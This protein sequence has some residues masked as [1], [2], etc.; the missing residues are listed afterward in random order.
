MGNDYARID[1]LQKDINIDTKQLDK[2]KTVFNINRLSYSDNYSAKLFKGTSLDP[3][4]EIDAISK[5]EE[6]CAKEVKQ[7]ND[8]KEEV[9]A[10]SALIHRLFK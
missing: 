9:Q 8:L 1:K 4:A 5:Q 10:P 7:L 2:M 6:I 3:D